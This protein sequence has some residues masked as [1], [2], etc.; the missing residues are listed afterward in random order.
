MSGGSRFVWFRLII[1]LSIFFSRGCYCNFFSKPNDFAHLI[2]S[3]SLALAGDLRGLPRRARCRR[4]SHAHAAV[5]SV[6][7]EHALT[8]VSQL[9]PW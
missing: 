2:G 8:M 1:L 9:T 3:S 6:C 4:R 5:V 7:G